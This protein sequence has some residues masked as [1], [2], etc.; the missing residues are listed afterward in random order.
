MSVETIECHVSK[1][2]AVIVSS[3]DG[4]ITKVVCPYFCY[5]LLCSVKQSGS[6]STIVGG[7]MDDSFGTKT[8]T[9]EYM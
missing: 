7:F 4:E 5:G 9:C 6:L 8:I 2:D 3:V 1:K